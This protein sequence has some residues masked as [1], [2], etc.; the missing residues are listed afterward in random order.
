MTDHVEMRG[1]LH[2]ASHDE[3]CTCE[4]QRQVSLI[5]AGLN[6]ED[7]TPTMT[8]LFARIDQ[9]EAALDEVG[10]ALVH[11]IG[12]GEGLWPRENVLAGEEP[13]LDLAAQTYDNVAAQN[14][15]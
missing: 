6:V 4:L 10:N 14:W 12:C 8:A 15:T 11:I 1:A 13:L 2:R 7:W 3:G 5:R 9:L